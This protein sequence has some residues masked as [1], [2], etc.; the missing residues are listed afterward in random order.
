MTTIAYDVTSLALA[1]MGGIAQVCRYTLEQAVRAEQISPVATYR[2]GEAGNITVPDVPILRVG[3]FSR[4]R[5]SQYDIVHALCH[6]VPPIRGRKLVYTLYD[7]W[8]LH[9]NRYQ[10]DKFQRLVG[11]RMRKELS[12][13]DAIISISQSTQAKLLELN[14]VDPNKCHVALM[15]VEQAP[16]APA[17]DVSDDVRNCSKRPF[18]LFV[19]KMEIRKNLGHVVDA[20]R[21]QDDL[22]LVVVGEPGFGYEGFVGDALARMPQDRL[23]ILSHLSAND[24]DWLYRNSLATLLPSWEEGFG[25][26]ILEAMV[27][28]CPVITS[29]CSA[30]AEVGGEAAVLVDPNDAS[31][32]TRA[33]ERLH[34]EPQF[35][36]QVI[37]AG[38]ERVQQF[39]WDK[40]FQ[41]VAAIYQGL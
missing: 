32:S 33:L 11:K 23:R 29:N 6:R 20:V 31:Q 3:R 30:S 5:L 28:G 19:G 24:L 15:G 37:Q 9:P 1:P 40:Y 39:G 41:G 25:L 7:A 27:R 4:L 8:S 10:S 36:E 26:P 21:S 14:I 12:R 17:S 18:V 35:R 22:D 16:V 2:R 34:D 13:A 38:L